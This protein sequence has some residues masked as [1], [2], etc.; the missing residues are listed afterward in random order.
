MR[1]LASLEHYVL[2]SS[3]EEIRLHQYISGRYSGSVGEGETTLEVETDYPWNGRVR[4]VVAAAPGG[5]WSLALRVPHWADDPSVRVN[6]EQLPAAVADGWLHIERDWKPGDELVLDLPLEPR[7]TRADPR[8]DA[9][10]G[11]VAVERGPLVYCIEAVD[12][13]GQRLDDLVVDPHSQPEL[14]KP[15][16]QLGPVAILR[17]QAT[18]RSRRQ[19]SWWPYAA[20]STPPES[21][22]GS[23]ALIAVPYY[24]WGNRGEGPMRVWLRA[25]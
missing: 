16:A 12:H 6:N 22:A 8:V 3:A 14:A 10:R 21:T 17:L 23:T 11:L 4:V 20:I 19:D 5:R 24:A 15:I 25:E 7:F 1:T 18:R 9:D 13:P 2:I